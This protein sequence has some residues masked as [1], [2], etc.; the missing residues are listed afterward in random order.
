MTAQFERAID[1]LSRKDLRLAVHFAIPLQFYGLLRTTPST[2]APMLTAVDRSDLSFDGDSGAMKFNY[3][4]LVQRYVRQ[5]ARTQPLVAMRYYCLLRDYMAPS[6]DEHVQRSLFFVCVTD[7]VLESQEWNMVLGQLDRD[8]RKTSA[9]IDC[10]L[11]DEKDITTMIDTVAREAERRGRIMDALRLY[12]LGHV[13]SCLFW[14]CVCLSSFFFLFLSLLHL[15]PPP[16]FLEF[17]GLF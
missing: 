14:Y 7:M 4:L 5:F 3:T 16:L 2:N 11:P 10:F 12:D 9:A 6:S 1:F 15:H 13:G 17:R 8:G